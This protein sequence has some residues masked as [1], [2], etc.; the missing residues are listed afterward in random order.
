MT[1]PTTTTAPAVPVPSQEEIDAALR[2]LMRA[3]APSIP[4]PGD[5]EP[6]DDEDDYYDPY[7]SCGCA[8]E[9]EYGERRGCNCGP[10]CS[11]EMC[12]YFDYAQYKRC[13]ARPDGVACGKTPTLRVVA[14]QMQTAYVTERVADGASCPHTEG[15]PHQCTEHTVHHEAGQKVQEY[16][17][18]PACSVAH[19]KALIADCTSG[20]Q[21]RIERWTYTPHDTELPAPLPDVRERTQAA[22]SAVK[23]AIDSLDRP[24]QTVDVWLAAVREHIACAA[25]NA[26]RPL[27]RPGD[28]DQVDDE[29]TTPPQEEPTDPWG[30]VADPEDVFDYAM[31]REPLDGHDHEDCDR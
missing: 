7:D 17:F 14:Y 1:E 28:D 12:E 2:T 19:A 31:D 6:E 3:W 21:H 18:R 10:G 8:G 5:P 25:W 11:C 4:L 22:H 27:E 29:P 24:G 13:W 20:L 15:Q 16:W 9:N 23:W 26:A 30:P